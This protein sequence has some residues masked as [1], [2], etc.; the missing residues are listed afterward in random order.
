MKNRTVTRNRLASKNRPARVR[1]LVLRNY[2]GAALAS[3]GLFTMMIVIFG[4]DLEDEIF[5]YQV[6]Q[7]ADRLAGGDIG[8]LAATGTVRSLDMQYFIGRQAM[9]DWLAASLDDSQPDGTD[10]IFAEEKG[11]FHVAVR[12]LDDGRTLYVVLNARPYIRSTPQI[13]SYLVIVGVMA[14]IF[15]LISLFF[16]HRM[17]RKVSRPL[18]DMAA[19]L[20]SD[21]TASARFDLTPGA[22]AELQALARAIEERDRRIGAFLDRERAFNRDASHELRTPLAVATGAAEVMEA[23]GTQGK[24]F[25]RLKTA[26]RDMHLLTEG[27]LWLGRE[28]ARATDCD[29]ATVCRDCT[30]AYS[31][32]ADGRAVS[33]HL[34]GPESVTMPVPEAV[35]HVLVGNILRNALAYTDRGD[36]RIQVR[37]GCVSVSDT[38]VG[39]GKAEKG[40]Q[41]FGVGLSLVRRL[42]THFDIGFDVTAD[43]RQGTLACLTW[44]V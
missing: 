9:P 28:V 32:L 26:L 35:A 20:G 2:M 15:L 3:F 36:I 34:D 10:E 22:P 37:P 38:G 43:T 5:D 18:E 16:I 31:H 13:K 23:S 24:A 12:P 41:G 39:F 14:G 7:T 8:A 11:H 27:I 30:A 4:F 19:A 6:R 44:P 1:G 25:S 42:C 21:D 40:R 33:V 29:V 17:T